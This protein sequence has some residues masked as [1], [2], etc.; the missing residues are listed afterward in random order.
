MN[1]V[2]IVHKGISYRLGHNFQKGNGKYILL[3][4]IS[5]DYAGINTR[6]E[7]PS[8]SRYIQLEAFYSHL[9]GMV[10]Q[11]NFTFYAGPQ[12]GIGYGLGF[13]PNWDDSHLYWSD[14]ISLGAGSLLCYKSRGGAWALSASLPF[15]SFISRPEKN[16]LYKIDDVTPGGIISS[17][18]SNW[19]AALWK[20][21]FGI[22]ARLEYE[23]SS[24]KK[25]SQSI[26]Y[27]FR[28]GY[29][30][31]KYG[32]PVYNLLHSLGLKLYF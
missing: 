12:A 9:L 10:K 21:N 22:N 32:M 1:L 27:S 19:Q 23:F 6:F 3:S 28:Y 26:G 11:R 29:M 17:M 8:A 16:R 25:L 2:P 15:F 13:Y 31:A 4:G 20:R 14:Y 24:V 5:A 7:G 18:N 30:E